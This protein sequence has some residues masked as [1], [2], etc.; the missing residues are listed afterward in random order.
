MKCL[1]QLKHWD[2]GFESQSRHGCLFVFILCLSKVATL[3][4]ADSPSKESYRLRLR[5][6][7]FGFNKTL[8]SS[9]M[10]AQL[11]AS[12]EGLS[13]MSEWVSEVRRSVSWMPYAPSGSNRKRRRRRRRRC[14]LMKIE[15]ISPSGT[16][17][18]I[19]QT[20]RS[21]VSEGSDIL[22][23]RRHHNKHWFG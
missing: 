4:R 23:E 20:T 1:R 16:L 19:Y 8:G 11:A 13:S 9:W 12:Q 7:T 14:C 17:V 3:R 15:A 6:W 2:R 5:K 21:H 10:T 18:R 22:G